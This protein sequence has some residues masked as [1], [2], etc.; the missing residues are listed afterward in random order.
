M[1]IFD[2]TRLAI[3]QPYFFPYIGYWQLINAVDRFMIYDDLSYIKRGW[4]NRNRILINKSPAYITVPL[5]RSSSNKRIRDIDLHPEPGWQ[6]RMIKTLEITYRRAPSYA[7]SFPVI[8]RLIR[9]QAENL[10]AYLAYQLRVLAAFLG[11]A[12]EIV[13]PGPQSDDENMRG[14]QRVLEVCKREGADVYINPQGGQGL[15]DP[16]FF[17]RGG[18]D[19]RFLVMHPLPYKQ[20][21]GGFMPYLSIIDALMEI[22]PGGLKAHLDAYA[23]IGEGSQTLAA[24]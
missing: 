18:V 3:M 5:H 2:M 11:I 9:H 4:I 19:L 14:Q 1:R 24:P 6:D 12:T 20:R 7:E 15:Y 16:R 8:E 17:R 21:A 10:S 22:G 13:T 23:L